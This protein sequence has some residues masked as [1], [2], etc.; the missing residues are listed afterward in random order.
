ML[1]YFSQLQQLGA[2]EQVSG[3]LLGAFTQ[4]E[5]EQCRPDV[6]TLLRRFIRPDLPVA[7]TAYIGH[8]T[9]S[10]AVLVGEYR[11]F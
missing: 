5:Q 8:G 9:D 7:R 4:M 10:R 11:K 6:W 3:I 2:F 1:T